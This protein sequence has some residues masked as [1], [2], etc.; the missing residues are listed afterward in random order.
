MNRLIFPTSLLFP[1]YVDVNTPC[2]LSFFFLFFLFELC[3]ID[4]SC[5]AVEHNTY[6]VWSWGLGLDN[7]S[8]LYCYRATRLNIFLDCW[9]PCDIFVIGSYFNGC[10]TQQLMKLLSDL[11]LYSFWYFVISLTI[12]TCFCESRPHTI[13]TI[14]TMSTYLVRDIVMFDFAPSSTVMKCF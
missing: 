4:A 2:F 14:S 3:L 8:I 6:F 10:I 11:T 5:K 12:F 7:I 9:Y 13:V 1:A